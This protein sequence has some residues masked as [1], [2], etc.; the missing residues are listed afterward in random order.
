ML[1][2]PKKALFRKKDLRQ[3]DSSILDAFKDR[4]AKIDPMLNIFRAQLGSFLTPQRF[5]LQIAGKD[6]EDS[7][8]TK[9]ESLLDFR[10]RSFRG[11]GFPRV[12]F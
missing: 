2:V 1:S 11:M 9:P 3:I 4:L 5:R 7:A 6:S 8:P 10:R 12:T